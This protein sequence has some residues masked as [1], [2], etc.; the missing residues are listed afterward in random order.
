MGFRLPVTR[1]G[2]IVCQCADAMTIPFGG[3]RLMPK[4]RKAVAY[5][6]SLR[7]GG[8]GNR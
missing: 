2:R 3:P 1:T 5:S 8:E 4:R 7:S 6:W